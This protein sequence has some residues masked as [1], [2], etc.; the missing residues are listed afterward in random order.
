MGLGS[1]QLVASPEPLYGFTGDAIISTRHIRLP[2]TVRESDLQATVMADFVIIDS[3]SAY[4]IIMGRPAMND[5]NLVVSIRALAI[6]FPTLNGI[7]YVKG[8]QYSISHCYE[9]V[10]KIGL[11]EKKINMVSGGE[12][13]AFSSNGVSHDLDPREVDCD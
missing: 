7:G 1:D 9:E 12:A 6:K 8:K 5:L 4:N 13:R 11:K 2:L 3:P 10:L